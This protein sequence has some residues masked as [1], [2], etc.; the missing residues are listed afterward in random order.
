MVQRYESY[1]SLFWLWIH[2]FVFGDLIDCFVPDFVEGI[3]IL[4]ITLIPEYLQTARLV[5]V[6]VLIDAPSHIVAGNVDVIIEL[7]HGFADYAY[8]PLWS[9]ASLMGKHQLIND[10]TIS[11]M[12]I[13]Q[14]MFLDDVRITVLLNLSQIEPDECG[15]VLRCMVI[16]GFHHTTKVVLLLE[17]PINVTICSLK[18]IA[19]V[20]VTLSQLQR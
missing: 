17:L 20:K 10:L 3:S 9:C 2:Q 4:P 1:E 18:A 14:G 15:L 13:S 5:D 12:F 16:L 6:G 11:R 19:L 7:T 8:H